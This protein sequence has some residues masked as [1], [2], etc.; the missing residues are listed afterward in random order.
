MYQKLDLPAKLSS[1]ENLKSRPPSLLNALTE[2]PRTLLDIGALCLSAPFLASMPR[3]DGHPV[4]VLP[5]FMA[6]D[7]STAVLTSNQNVMD[8]FKSTTV[9]TQLPTHRIIAELLQIA[10]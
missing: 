10:S 2:I 6:S 3:G 7:Q 8:N 1:N 5:G 9:L 4:M